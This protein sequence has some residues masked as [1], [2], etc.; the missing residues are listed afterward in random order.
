MDE[1]FIDVDGVGYSINDIKKALHLVGADD[2]KAV[3]VHSDIMFGKPRKGFKRKE[4][5]R[6]LYNI[7][8][9]FR[10][11]IIVPT[12]TFSF[13]NHDDFDV[14]ESRTSM[15]AFNEYV[16]K[17]DGRY[18]TL[19]PI[20][21]VSVPEHM[22]SKFEVV[23][24]NSLGADSGLDHLHHLDGVKFLFLGAD[25]GDCFTY[26]HYV[27]KMMDVPYR[28]DMYFE[29]NITDYEGHIFK[30]KQAI[31]TQCKGVILPDKYD[32]FENKMKD[33]GILKSVRVGD[34]Y[35]SCVSEKD[36]YKAIQD[37][38]LEDPFYYL[39][40]PYDENNLIHEYTYDYTK[41]RIT[42]C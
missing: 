11:Q 32:Y 39:K 12:F 21:S 13:C 20:L 16:R 37:S 24:E 25:V 4:Y 14:N 19:D 10:I 33:I 1:L 28:F 22:K 26:V 17:Q 29:G 18:R 6:N 8:N 42:H 23:G 2:C 27:E 31:H 30:R 9:E 34:K 35:I 36:A 38:I 41:G 40:Q 3:F 7:L 15:G 5:L